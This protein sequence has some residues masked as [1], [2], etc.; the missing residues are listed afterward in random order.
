MLDADLTHHHH[1]TLILLDER[2]D[3]FE[4]WTYLISGTMFETTNRQ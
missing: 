1:T 2:N 4:L 3:H